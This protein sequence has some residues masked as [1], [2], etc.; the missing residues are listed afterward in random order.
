[1]Y[2]HQRHGTGKATGDGALAP[3][4]LFCNANFFIQSRNRSIHPNRPA[5]SSPVRRSLVAA[6]RVV[7]ASLGPAGTG[8]DV[9]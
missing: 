6:A 7:A 5:L 1:V 4:E 3:D 8:H 2:Q 9:D